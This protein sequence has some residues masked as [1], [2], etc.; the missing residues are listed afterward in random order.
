M[1]RNPGGTED[2]DSGREKGDRVLPSRRKL[3]QV[4][5][6]AVQRRLLPN[7]YTEQSLSFFV[8]I[9]D[10]VI[11][12]Q[13]LVACLMIMRVY[14]LYGRKAWVAILYAGV[15]VCS[16]GIAIWAVITSTKTAESPPVYIPDG[17]GVTLARTEARYLAFAWLSELMFDVLI[18]VMTLYKTL[19]LPNGN[20][21]GLLSMLMRDGAVY[22][23]AM[24]VVNIGN[25]ITFFVGGPLSR[26][27]LT[28]LANM[29]YFINN[30]ISI[31]VEPSR[32][33]AMSNETTERF[34]LD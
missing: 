6:I 29:Q 20:G 2:G 19:S 26:G 4:L 5:M 3:H 18:F 27:S 13:C 11:T 34:G 22:F 33:K 12:I 15:A 7:C 8:R 1:S 17:C 16:T 28:M 25:I 10:L 32:S 9:L 30:N 31:D 23:G 14:A 24:V 21:I